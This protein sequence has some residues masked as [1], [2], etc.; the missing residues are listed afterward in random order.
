MSWAGLGLMALCSGLFLSCDK[1]VAVNQKNFPDD[2]FREAVCT[3]LDVSEG[4]KVPKEKFAGMKTLNLSSLGIKDLKGIEY[5]TGLNVLYCGDNLLTS[6]DL[7]QNKALRTVELVGNELSSLDF[8]HNPSLSQLGCSYNRLTS[9]DVTKNP[10][11]TVLLCNGNPLESIDLSGNPLLYE[12]GVNECKLNSLDLTHNL[13]LKELYCKRNKFAE[14]DLT[15]NKKMESLVYEVPLFGKLHISRPEGKSDLGGGSIQSWS[16][17]LMLFDDSPEMTEKHRRLSMNAG[18]KFHDVPFDSLEFETGMRLS[19]ELLADLSRIQKPSLSD[20]T[21]IKEIMEKWDSYPE[22]VYM[23]DIHDSLTRSQRIR[24]YEKEVAFFDEF[25]RIDNEVSETVLKD[26]PFLDF[27]KAG[28]DP[29]MDEMRE[30]IPLL[31]AKLDEEIK[32]LKC[33]PEI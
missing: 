33:E 4:A 25:M 14:L 26:F 3:Y 15:Q 8:S 2:A 20:T 22:V 10:E 30:I 9:I 1:N 18:L 19:D 29:E 27:T 32:N 12:L 5:F 21:M 31:R 17:T 13:E 7:S 6:V 28:E 24:F 23:P 11:L 16:S